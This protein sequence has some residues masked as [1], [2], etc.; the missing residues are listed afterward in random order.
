M[1]T[2]TPYYYWF[3]GITE[4]KGA[5]IAYGS[6]V[7]ARL[8]LPAMTQIDFIKMVCHLFGLVPDVTARDRKIRFWNY[9]ELY[10]NFLQA[11]DWSPYLSERDDEVEFKF[12]DYAQNNYLKYKQSQDVI[13]DNGMGTLILN[14]ETLPEEKD[15]VQASVSTCDEVKILLNVFSVDTSRL[16][17]N[18]YNPE[19]DLYTSNK[20][21]DPRVVYIDYCREDASP[22]YQKALWIRE[23]EAP[24]TPGTF[25]THEILTP[26]VAQS[27]EV[28][29]SNMIAF[30]ASLSRLLTKTNLRRAKFNLPVYE[31][32][33][34]KHNIPIYL[35]QY[36]AYFYVNKISNY[37]AGQ[38]CMIDLIKL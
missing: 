20:T 18:K 25:A 29:F 31:V 6:L 5:E 35:S 23:T 17:F 37:V 14:D 38:L 19:T 2:A 15:I 22:F 24:L 1:T 26:K 3:W 32:A 9:S 36:K 30:Y 33:G 34:L 13:T 10:D 16:A 8:H 11:R 12:G 27:L 7:D 21:I 28:S 4:I